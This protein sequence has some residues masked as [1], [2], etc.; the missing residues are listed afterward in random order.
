MIW[1]ILE[2]VILVGTICYLFPFVRVVGDSM[3]PTYN[4]GQ[5]LPERNVYI[6]C[7]DATTF[8]SLTTWTGTITEYVSEKVEQEKYWVEENITTRPAQ[9]QSLYHFLFSPYEMEELFVSILIQMEIL[10]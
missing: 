4:D 10:Y 2:V 9:E 7:V 3:L 6:K 8:L 1:Y 5:L